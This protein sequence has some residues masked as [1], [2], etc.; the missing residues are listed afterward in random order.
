MDNLKLN[1]G[2][3]KVTPKEKTFLVQKVFSD[4]AKKI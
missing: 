2:K 1:F 4:V 3:R